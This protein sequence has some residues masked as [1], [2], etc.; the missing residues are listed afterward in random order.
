MH[1][2]FYPITLYLYMKALGTKSWDQFIQEIIT[3]FSFLNKNIYWST[4]Y[5][6]STISS[7]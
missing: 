2:I 4:R 7:C 3:T 1:Q 6:S 5:I